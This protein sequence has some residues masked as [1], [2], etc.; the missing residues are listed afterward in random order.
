M[1]E[2]KN[3]A[4]KEKAD[5]AVQI[6]RTAKG[7]EVFTTLLPPLLMIGGAAAL[8]FAGKKI[9][10]GITNTAGEAKDFLTKRDAIITDAVVEQE[11]LKATLSKSEAR[12]MAQG[13]YDA[14][15][16]FGTDEER[17]KEIFERI[18]NKADFLM[19]YKEF[20]LRPYGDFGADNWLDKKLSSDRHL[21][22][23]LKEEISEDDV[24]YN[25]V[26]KWVTEAGF[27]F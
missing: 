4:I 2:N 22:Y 15:E 14:M 23:W 20:G 19:V 26:N 9:F 1:A 10:S 6:V 3:T 18:Q 8:F 17:I 25:I 5:K 7:A 16:G 11:I 21:V 24:C 12:R 27:G 13:L